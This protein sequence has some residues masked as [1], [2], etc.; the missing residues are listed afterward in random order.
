MSKFLSGKTNKVA[1]VL[2]ALILPRL[3]CGILF[4]YDYGIGPIISTLLTILLMRYFNKPFFKKV[5]DD[6]KRKKVSVLIALAIFSFCFELTFLFF[7]IKNGKAEIRA[8]WLTYANIISPIIIAPISEEISFRWALTETGLDKGT[9][10]IKKVFFLIFCL[11]IWNFLHTMDLSTINASVILLGLILYIIYLRSENII[12]C[13]FTHMAANLSVT[14]MTSPI[15]TCL[16][17]LNNN[18]TALYICIAV[19]VLTISYAFARLSLRSKL[20]QE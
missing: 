16:S 4:D 5:I 1:A 6:S 17:K 8:H 12:Y 2:L 15:Q 10:M 14:V 9:K 11:I 19:A 7:A 13:I 3:L 18:N 20:K